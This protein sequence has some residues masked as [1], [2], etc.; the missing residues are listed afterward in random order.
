MKTPFSFKASALR[1]LFIYLFITLPVKTPWSAFTVNEE[2][3]ASAWFLVPS[4]LKAACVPPLLLFG[5]C[6][7]LLSVTLQLNWDTQ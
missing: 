2:E 6:C 1:L 3:V 5:F 7:Y 4:S